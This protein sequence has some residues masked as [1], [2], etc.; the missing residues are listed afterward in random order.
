MQ[1][2]MQICS[3]CAVVALAACD[4][5]AGSEAPK[6]EMNSGMAAA[7]GVT[8][9]DG[10]KELREYRVIPLRPMSGDVE[11]LFGDPEAVGEPFV[12]RIRELPGTIVPPHSHPVDEHLT[13]VKGTWYFGLGDTYDVQ[14][15]QELKPGTYAFAPKGSSMFGY[16]PEEAIV[17]VHGIGPFQ[18]HWHGGLRTL[19]DPDA[20]TT[21][22]FA[23][24]QRIASPRGGGRIVEGYGSGKIIQY[25]IEPSAGGRFMIN[26]DE[27][28]VE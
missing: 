3:F 4:R 7:T 20:K 11:I 21:F 5:G 16:A 14:R 8:R 13:V 26:E 2:W 15:L 9:A 19:D 23:R 17:Q 12:M 25:E 24:G 10:G 27:V 1:R 22:R 18:I 28:R 6:G